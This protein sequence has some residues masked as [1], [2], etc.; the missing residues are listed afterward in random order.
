MK[1]IAFT[2]FALMLAGVTLQ[3][4]GAILAGTAGGVIG[5]EAAEN[6]GRF[7]PLQ[8]T[9]VGQAIYQ[10]DNGTYVGDKLF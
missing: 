5:S 9:D 10:N 1:R 6:N 4:C 2:V 3:G 7:D 8:N